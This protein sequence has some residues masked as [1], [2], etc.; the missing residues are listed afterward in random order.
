LSIHR[1]RPSQSG[2]AKDAL[3][4]IAALRPVLHTWGSSAG[5]RYPWRAC[6]DPYQRLLAEVLLQRTRADAVAGVWADVI[7]AF[8]SPSDLSIATEA[9]IAQVIRPLGFAN[10]RAAYLKSMGRDL[11]SLGRVP[12]DISALLRIAG[13]GSYS[14]GA[15]LISWNAIRA[16]PV[17]C[18]VRRVLGRV[19]FGVNS[20]DSATAG[21]L[22][23]ELLKTGDPATLLFAVIDLGS[24]P[25]RPRH[26]LCDECPA[27]SFCC[28]G[29]SRVVGTTA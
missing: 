9:N 8:P 4:Q 2:R 13:I 25:C 15:F 18:N 20:T 11:V 10:K 17:D 3:S 24:R 22:M 5:R 19:A 21:I 29:A 28:Y 6:G 26:P 23:T 16:S 7:E 27:Q 12:D 14:A 1:N